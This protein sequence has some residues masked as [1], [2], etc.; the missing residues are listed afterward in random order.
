MNCSQ[1]QLSRLIKILQVLTYCAILVLGSDA[2]LQQCDVETGQTNIILDIEESKAER[3][4][5]LIFRCI[6]HTEEFD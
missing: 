1:C 3:E 6:T 4:Y 2:K 5:F